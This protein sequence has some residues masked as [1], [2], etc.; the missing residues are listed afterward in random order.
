MPPTVGKN[1]RKDRYTFRVDAIIEGDIYTMRYADGEELC[2]LVC[3]PPA[4]W[5]SLMLVEEEGDS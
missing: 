3:I 1:Y 4:V 2:E 5:E